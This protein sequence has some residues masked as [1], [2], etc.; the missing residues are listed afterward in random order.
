MPVKKRIDKRRD[1]VITD[2]AIEIFR[3]LRATARRCTCGPDEIESCPACARALDSQSQLHAELNLPP[4]IW[5]CIR[6]T[7]GE[8]SDQ[9][10]VGAHRS[11]VSQRELW[12]L[13]RRPSGR[14]SARACRGRLYRWR[15]RVHRRLIEL[16][17]QL[18]ADESLNVGARVME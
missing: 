6:P 15:R 7:L 12:Q 9:R 10:F 8:C 5:P 4:W 1:V 17:A 18:L 16:L 13:L 3:E 2:R 14:R 11:W